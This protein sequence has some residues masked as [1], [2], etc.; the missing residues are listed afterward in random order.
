MQLE[1]IIKGI[2]HEAIIVM[3][4]ALLAAVIVGQLPTVR[5]WIKLQ[6]NGVPNT[7]N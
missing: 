4:G 5:D 7:H 6:W 2:G 3:G 1:K